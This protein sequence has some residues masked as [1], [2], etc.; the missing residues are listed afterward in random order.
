MPGLKTE[1]TELAVAFGILNREPL[2][3]NPDELE[4]LFEG[5]LTPK[6]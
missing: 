5:T 4:A 6:K 2:S 3:V 1:C